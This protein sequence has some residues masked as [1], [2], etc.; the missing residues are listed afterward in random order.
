M[1]ILLDTNILIA[2]VDKTPQLLENL[3]SL[4]ERLCL[5]AISVC[6][7]FAMS[8]I[9]QAEE[10]SIQ[11]SLD[12]YIK[13]IPVDYDVGRKAATLARTRPG[14]NKRIDL[15]IAATALDMKCPL[16]TLNTRDFRTIPSLKILEKEK[17]GV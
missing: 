13:V 12:K 1:S 11:D 17:L 2:G 10:K 7:L 8:G 15:I 9:S 14:R 6:E 4:N 16:A 5:S 3:I